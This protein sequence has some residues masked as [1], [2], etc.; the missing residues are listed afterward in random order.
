MAL[1]LS[2]GVDEKSR[3][4]KKQ[5]LSKISNEQPKLFLSDNTLTLNNSAYNFLGFRDD[6]KNY[7]SFCLDIHDNYIPTL[8][9]ST[10]A[11]I[12]NINKYRIYS[13]NSFRFKTLYSILNEML[14]YKQE[15]SFEIL[16][17]PKTKYK[18]NVLELNIL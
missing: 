5:S 3:I 7:I 8:Y 16:L 4:V 9:N 2:L 15:E 18:L 14:N 12:E 6:N 1:N 13:N 17:T 10:D 11:L